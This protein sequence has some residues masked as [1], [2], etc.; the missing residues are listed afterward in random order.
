MRL[1]C[2]VLLPLILNTS[3]YR[4]NPLD[5]LLSS[6]KFKEGKRY[7]MY[8]LGESPPIIS[9][10]K[11][12]LIENG[13]LFIPKLKKEKRIDTITLEMVYVE[14][15]IPEIKLIHSLELPKGNYFIPS[16]AD[17]ICVSEEN[18]FL[19][20]FLGLNKSLEG[21]NFGLLD[22]KKETLEA[23]VN[24]YNQNKSINEYIIN[25][26]PKHEW[27]SITDWSTAGKIPMELGAMSS[28]Y[29][30]VAGNM[31]IVFNK[32]YYTQSEEMRCEEQ[33]DKKP[34]LAVQ[35]A[36]SERG[37]NNP[38]NNIMDNETKNALVKFQKDNYLPIGNL[39]LETLDALG[40]KY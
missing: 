24:E 19:F 1:L 25:I 15:S 18:V 12:V 36:L 35:K 22:N 40:I 21:I 33:V 3:C 28:S 6:D 2:I 37:Y 29:K 26:P 23:F 38:L 32:G 13:V 9:K 30:D 4:Q 39:N 5:V 31:Y 11:R 14:D 10:K 34:I 20:Q 7:V 17:D 16:Y 8:D 27:F